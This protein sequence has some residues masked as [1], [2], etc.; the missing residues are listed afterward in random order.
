VLDVGGGLILKVLVVDDSIFVRHFIRKLILDAYPDT[1]V[2][3]ASSGSDGF[4]IYKENKPDIIITDLLMPGVN[5]HELIKMVKSVNE[6]V[7]I[8]VLS[9]DI[10]NAVK[11][12]VL[13]YGVT[14]FL[15]K[16]LNDE[17]F[18]VVLDAIGGG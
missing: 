6:D 1:E 15:N 17:K 5:G 2:L 11:K 4:E 12:E 14:A 10:Q 7:K 8:F 13:G 3:F 18:Q 16:P 9:A